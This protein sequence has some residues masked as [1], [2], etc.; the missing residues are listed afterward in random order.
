MG[1]HLRSARNDFSLFCAR[2]EEGER[3][4]HFRGFLKARDYDAACIG[5]LRCQ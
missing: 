4:R 3:E 1:T 5:N 2:A